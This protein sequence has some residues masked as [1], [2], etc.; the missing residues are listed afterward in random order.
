MGNVEKKP[1]V[2]VFLYNRLFDPLIQSNFWLYIK[3]YL[4]DPSNPC[5]KKTLGY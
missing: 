5:H 2:I 3:D 4:E 1:K